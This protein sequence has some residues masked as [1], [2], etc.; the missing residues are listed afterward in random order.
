[1]TASI[2]CLNVTDM[3]VICHVLSHYVILSRGKIS[4]V[5]FCGIWL[6]QFMGTYF[7]SHALLLLGIILSFSINIIFVLYLM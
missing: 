5:E 2:S 6:R 3:T 1:M 7:I 4:T